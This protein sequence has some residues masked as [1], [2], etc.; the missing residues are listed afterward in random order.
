M[1]SLTSYVGSQ[2]IVAARDERRVLHVVLGQVSQQLADQEESVRLVLHGHVTDAGFLGVHARP[3]QLLEG[4]LLVGHRLDHVRTGHEHVGGAAHHEDEIGQRRRI[5]CSPGAGSQDGR[6]LRDHSGGQRVVQED[7]GV[8]GQRH[9]PLLDAGAAR[10]VQPDD[11]RPILQRQVEHFADLLGVYLAQASAQD[12]EVLREDVDQAPVDR[13][14]AGHDA[15]P[16]E[17]LCL[18]PEIVAA[19]HDERIG[20][21]ERVLVE[22]Q[23]EA[24]A[25][26]QLALLALGFCALRSAA[27]PGTGFAVTEN[28]EFPVIAHGTLGGNSA[29]CA[30][31]AG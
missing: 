3:A 13:P 24:L 4:D 23:V 22:Q 28:L 20:F 8:A 19:M 5:D 17:N 9:H 1:I 27:L 26:G 11:R 18:Q 29:R 25:A 14:P 12:G 6:D 15:V 31:K 7:V 10:V 21:V 16:G 30:G 2:W